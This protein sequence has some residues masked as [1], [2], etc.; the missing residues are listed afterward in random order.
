MKNILHQNVRMWVRMAKLAK[1]T[2]EVSQGHF[3]E[4]F[5]RSGRNRS[6]TGT[7]S[8]N[9]ASTTFVEI[10]TRSLESGATP[11]IRGKDGSFVTFPSATKV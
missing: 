4:G 9:L 7:G 10:L 6:L 1:I 2:R 5:A 8:K 11:W 3:L